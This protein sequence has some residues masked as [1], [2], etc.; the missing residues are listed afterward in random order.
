MGNSELSIEPADPRGEDARVCLQTYFTELNE[1]FDEG[2]DPS[3]TVSAH[4]E[5]LTPPFGRFLIARLDGAPV[6]CGALKL[7]EGGVGEIKRMW[8]ARFARGRGI[9]QRLLEALEAHA[10]AAGVDVLQLDTHRNLTE[11][12]KF[13]LRN[14]YVAIPA[15]NDN[16]YAHHWFEKRGLQ[17]SRN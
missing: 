10:I 14:G 4:P 11:A 16:P 13:Y 6:G 15:Y 7:K 17:P 3:M 8:V 9:A 2:F 5:E 12:R 1:R